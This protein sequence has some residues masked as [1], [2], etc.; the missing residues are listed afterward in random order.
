MILACGV[1]AFSVGPFT[2]HGFFQACLFSAPGAVL[3]MARDMQPRRIARRSPSIRDLRGAGALRVPPFSGFFSG[4]ILFNTWIRAQ[5]IRALG[6]GQRHVGADGVLHV[7][8]DLQTF[9][10]SDNVARVKISTHRSRIGS[11]GRLADG[12]RRG[13]HRAA[14]AWRTSGIHRA[15]HDFVAPYER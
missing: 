1:S 2:A 11:A 13:I 6:G 4:E 10:S 12:L 14:G 15:V 7:P 5:R 8:R 3:R 9:F